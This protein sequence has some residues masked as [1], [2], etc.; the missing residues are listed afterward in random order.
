MSLFEDKTGIKLII[1]III[2]VVFYGVTTWLLNWIHTC[3]LDVDGWSAGPS[4]LF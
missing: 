4:S 1:I 2:V 3:H